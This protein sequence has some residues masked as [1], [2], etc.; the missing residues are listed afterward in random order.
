MAVSHQ[1]VALEVASPREVALEVASPRA[2]AL[3]AAAPPQAGTLHQR[4]TSGANW[5]A[6]WAVGECPLLLVAAGSVIVTMALA[7]SA[8]SKARLTPDRAAAASASSTTSPVKAPL[9]EAR[10]LVQV[11]SAL[12]VAVW[13]AETVVAAWTFVEQP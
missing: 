5:K 12:A 4:P 6:I 2:V 13:A 1:A 9:V 8:A 7:S 10:T 11:M 3:E